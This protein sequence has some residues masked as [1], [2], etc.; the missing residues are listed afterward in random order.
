MVHSF[1]PDI[2]DNVGAN[3]AVIFNYIDYCCRANAENKTN[4]YDGKFWTRCPLARLQEKFDYLTKEQIRYAVEKLEKSGYIISALLNNSAYD[5]TKWYTLSD[6]EWAR[7]DVKLFE[8]KERG[9]K[10]CEKAQ[11]LAKRK[12]AKR[13][14]ITESVSE[15][16]PIEQIFA[17]ALETR[18]KNS[19]KLDHELLYASQYEIR[20]KYTNNRYVVDFIIYGIRGEKGLKPL[21]IELD[22]KEYHSSK[23]QINYDYKRANELLRAGYIVMRFSGSQVYN[24]ATACVRQAIQTFYEINDI[25]RR[26]ANAEEND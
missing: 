5:R 9:G 20:P 3:A 6:K 12:R 15:L 25:K 21:V 19:K 10:L 16:T 7:K 18:I 14:G 24:G 17:V 4:E 2:A 1:R 26:H 23:E 13:V 22:G 8:P 11:K